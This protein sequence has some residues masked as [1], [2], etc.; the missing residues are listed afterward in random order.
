MCLSILLWNDICI[1]SRFGFLWIQSYYEH[2]CTH[3][4]LDRFSSHVGKYL[5]TELLGKGRMLKTN[6][7]TTYRHFQRFPW[8]HCM[9][10][11]MLQILIIWCCQSYFSHASGMQ[12]YLIV[13]FS[14]LFFLRCIF[15]FMRDIERGRDIGRVLPPVREPDVGL[16]PKTP[17]ITTRDKGKRSTTEPSGIPIFHFSGN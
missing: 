13:V 4:F 16:D 6:K 5:G 7:Q 15:L 8:R 10:L 12:W 9:E 14:F 1:I 3:L 17:G 11:Q 2:S